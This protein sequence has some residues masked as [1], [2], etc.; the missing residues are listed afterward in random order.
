[1]RSVVK[2]DSPFRGQSLFIFTILV[3]G[4]SGLVAQVVLLRE[5]LVNFLGNEL[6]LGII[7]ANW[8]IAEALG[9]WLGGRYIDRAKNK[10]NVFIDVQIAF[11][12]ALFLALYLS[13]IFKI[14]LGVPFGEGVGLFTVL[15]ASFL[16]IFPVA[17]SHGVLFSFAS[18]IYR[19]IGRVYSYE[20]IGTII[21]GFLIT[22]LLIPYL[23][24]FQIIFMVA[25]VNL[26]VCALLFK[27]IAGTTLKYLISG[28]FVLTVY[29]FLSGEADTLQQASISRQYKTAKIIDYQNSVYGNIAVTKQKEQYTFFYNGIPI[30][31]IPYPDITFTEEFGH[32][33]LLFHHAPKDI[34]VLSGGAGGLINEILKHPVRKI[35]YAELD[36]LL[37]ETIKKYP[38]EL[39]K[40]ELGDSRVKVI[41]ADG[42]FFV[43]NTANKY[44]II[45]IGISKPADLSTNRLF[46]QEFF[47][48]VKKRLNPQGVLALWLPGSLIYL[49][50]QLRDINACIIN[51]LKSNYAYLRIIPGD[52]N[53]LLAS[54]S[55]DIMQVDSAL[56]SQRIK[57]QN[58]S[59]NFLIPSYL[60]YRLDKKWLEWF[61]S[62]SAGA[63]H[64]VNKD[65]EPFAVFSALVFWN[66]EFSPKF[67][68]FLAILENLNLKFIFILIF[69]STIIFFF[70]FSCRPKIAVTYSIATTGF[71]GMLAN[72]ILIFAFQVFYGY[73]YQRI[74]ILGSIFMAGI[75]LGSILVTNNLRRIKNVL[76]LFI[77]FEL[78]ITVFSFILPWLIVKFIGWYMVLFFLAGLL[79][80]VEFPLAA[81]IYSA[82]NDKIGATVGA[83]YSADLLGGWL[84]GVLGGVILLPLLGL[85]NACMVMVFL[86]LSSLAILGKC[87]TR[88]RI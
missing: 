39:T 40:K 75:A 6:I 46:T 18:K 1:M 16:I 86:K 25:L 60:E 41:N 71:F 10:I 76:K 83:L 27:Q 26:A 72:L 55:R 64:R 77:I 73:L 52:Y 2:R 20:T 29:L 78:L 65:M 84:A 88:Q 34:L 38:T 44:D 8:V 58:I 59:T 35:D 66:K 74:G 61:S 36:P 4:L 53:I 48:L 82:N 85:F 54:S 24:S 15:Y 22:Y 80:G 67:A 32:L 11:S 57:E 17:L 42:R 56:I 81:R 68:S 47:A 13:R 79:M 3:V 7:L 30:I 43:R 49:S 45:L 12:V 50:P 21:G 70:L 51:A 9:A 33:P 31:T 69:I 28:L 5:L 87:F 37:I 23:N 19:S 63:T 14:T 62:A